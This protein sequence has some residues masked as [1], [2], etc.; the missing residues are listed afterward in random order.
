M[1]GIQFEPQPPQS[2]K[3]LLKP[4]RLLADKEQRRLKRRIP[5]LLTS[6]ACEPDF[7]DSP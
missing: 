6:L 2:L 3:R 4:L 5:P 7:A 1:R